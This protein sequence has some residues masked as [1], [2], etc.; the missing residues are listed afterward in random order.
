MCFKLLQEDCIIKA[1]L[2]LVSIK[3]PFLLQEIGELYELEQNIE[4]AILYFDRAADYFED[5]AASSLANQ[6]KD[7]VA[8]FSAQLEQ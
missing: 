6:C 5:Q 1:L 3:L 8:Q 4:K 2:I 7:K